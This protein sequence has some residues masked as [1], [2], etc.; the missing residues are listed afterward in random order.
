MPADIQ[1]WLDQLA[2]DVSSASSS[3]SSS[4]VQPRVV[5]VAFGTHVDLPVSVLQ[6]LSS[7]LLAVLEA[8]YADG[9]IWAVR[10]EFEFVLQS[11]HMQI[12]LKSKYCGERFISTCTCP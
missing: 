2:A 8:G 10:C 7:A 4:S 11:L 6:H 3:S 1:T 5:Y 9:V 12:V